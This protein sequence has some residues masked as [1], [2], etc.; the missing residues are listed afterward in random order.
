MDQCLW[1]SRLE[2]RQFCI[3]LGLILISLIASHV[4]EHTRENNLPKRGTIPLILLKQIQCSFDHITGI[5]LC[6][7]EGSNRADKCIS[8]DESLHTEVSRR[9]TSNIIIDID[10]EPGI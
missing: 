2:C 4:G 7:D 3:D 9:G 8:I 6:C 1:L 10:I 5:R